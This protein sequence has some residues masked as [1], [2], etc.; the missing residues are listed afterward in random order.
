[1]RET[2][3]GNTHICGNRG[4]VKEGEV[5]A[6]ANGHCEATKPCSGQSWRENSSHLLAD[7]APTFLPFFE[8]EQEPLRTRNHS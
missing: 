4:S 5:A 6:P 3:R 1:M 7:G 8:Q 2:K